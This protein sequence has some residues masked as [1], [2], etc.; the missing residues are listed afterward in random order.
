ME[1]RNFYLRETSFVTGLAVDKAPDR[2]L[3]PRYALYRYRYHAQYCVRHGTL[4]QSI[5]GDLVGISKTG[6]FTADRSHAYT[7]INI[8]EPSLMMLSSNTQA[9]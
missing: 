1:Q 3:H 4:L 2:R 5:Q 6:L 8:V 7:L 9:S